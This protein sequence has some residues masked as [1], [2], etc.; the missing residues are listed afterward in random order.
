MLQLL[1]LVYLWCYDGMWGLAPLPSFASS[2][3]QPCKRCCTWLDEHHPLNLCSGISNPGQRGGSL[4]T[5][6]IWRNPP[7]SCW[8]CLHFN[9]T[10]FCFYGFSSSDKTLWTPLTASTSTLGKWWAGNVSRNAALPECIAHL[11]TQTKTT[12]PVDT[13]SL[14]VSSW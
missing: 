14:S 7:C 6:L 13:K 5:S 10:M 8:I 1:Y 9:S 4:G 12:D 2:L 3:R 11:L